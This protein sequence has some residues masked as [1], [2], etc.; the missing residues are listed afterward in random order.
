MIVRPPSRVLAPGDVPE[1]QRL[2]EDA[3]EAEENLVVMSSGSPH[4]R[5]GLA[6]AEAH[7]LVDLSAWKRV[8]LVDRRNRVCR[9]EPGVTYD[10]LLAA[11]QP[12]GMTL[13]MPL[14]PRSTKSVLAAVMDREPSTWPNKQWDGSDPVGS[15]EFLFGTGEHFR[16]G[17]AGGPGSIDAQRKVGG[18]QKFS[19]GPSH[20]DFHRVLQGAQGTMGVVTWAT[21]RAELAPSIEDP[22]LLRADSLDALI[23]YVYDVQRALL[24]EQSFILNA[25]AA[26]MLMAGMDAGLLV[27]L[28]ESLPPF[29]CLQNIAGFERLPEE[30]LAYQRDDIGA[31]A[32]RH[33]LELLQALDAVSAR[34]LLSHANN[35]CGEIDWRQHVHGGCLSVFFL[36]TLDRAPELAACFTESAK[37]YGVH[38]SEIGLYV[39]PVVQN[40]GCHIELT[41]SYDP[42]SGTAEANMQRLEEDAVT[43]LLD[44]GAFF[45]RPYG[46]ADRIFAKNPA[47]FA[48]IRQVKSL[49]DPNRVLHR[50]KWGL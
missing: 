44:A 3:N 26:A 14:A 4:V 24:G 34:D 2:I 35:T 22:H 17:A 36:S 23:P 37:D 9:V 19:S 13:P 33:G 39:Q 32:S 1:L 40:H 25:R 11:L 16:T 21:L 5:D 43:R 28:C 27:A 10:E 49:F 8:D 45:S 18:A 7:A 38:E 6:T 47:N 29:L 31:H 42:S 20:T 41:V 50:G 30:R 46:T 48:L 15:T 12:H